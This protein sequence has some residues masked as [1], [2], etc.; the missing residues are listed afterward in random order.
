MTHDEAHAIL[1]IAI[2]LAYKADELDD[3]TAQWLREHAHA[4]AAVA[5]PK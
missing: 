1:D 2:E 3:Q 5:K 4:L